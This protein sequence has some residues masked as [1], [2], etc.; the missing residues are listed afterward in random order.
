MIVSM[1]P[2]IIKEIAEFELNET[3]QNEGSD[4]DLSLSNFDRIVYD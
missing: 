3:N 4:E 1:V 2:N